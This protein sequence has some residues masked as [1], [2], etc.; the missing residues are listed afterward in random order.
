MLKKFVIYF[1]IC[2]LVSGIFSLKALKVYANGT[3][4][5]DLDFSG[6][7]IVDHAGEPWA[8]SGSVYF[9]GGAAVFGNFNW[10]E[11]DPTSS[12]GIHNVINGNQ[13]FYT[14]FK[15]KFNNFGA[16]HDRILGK[17]GADYGIVVRYK[18]SADLWEVRLTSSIDDHTATF[19]FPDVLSTGINYDVAFSREGDS[20]K[21]YRD[22]ELK[23]TTSIG[24][25]T[26]D[27]AGDTT[28]VGPSDGTST[29]TAVYWLKFIGGAGYIPLVNTTVVSI[30][31]QPG[32]LALQSPTLSSD[33]TTVT[34]NGLVQKT[35]AS[36]NNLKVSDATGSLSGFH[37]Q[38]QATVFQEIA[39]AGYLLPVGSLKL[40]MPTSVSIIQGTA[41]SSPSLSA[42]TP[43][44]IDNGSPI[45]IA[46][47]ATGKGAGEFDFIFSAQALELSLFPSTTKTDE[48]NYSGTA[49]PYQSIITWSII[50]GP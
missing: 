22:G 2:F 4:L 9:S 14:N 45:Q 19:T 41:S 12:M 34:L 32:S 16:T 37:V 20:L 33:F 44:S 18:K 49:T 10:L 25:P 31:I 8:N 15:L 3:T 13:N 7:N 30:G 24:F 40:S 43:T 21:Y 28:Y 1:S 42:V 26:F 29:D 38:A 5:I 48:S 11:L 23:S 27:V 39:G 35:Y 36:L 46:S 47:A 17:V 50:A 6:N